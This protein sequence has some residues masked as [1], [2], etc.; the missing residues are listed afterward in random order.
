MQD[1]F[2]GYVTY[3]SAGGV[4]IRSYLVVP[5]GGSAPPGVL[6]LRG[7]AGPDDGYV[8]IANRFAKSG[9]GVLVHGWQVRGDDP[10]DQEVAADAS[11]ALKYLASRND[12][13]G[14]DIGVVGYCRGGAHGAHRPVLLRALA[15]QRCGGSGLAERAAQQVRILYPL[16]EFVAEDVGRKQRRRV[17]HRPQPPAYLH[18]SRGPLARGARAALGGGGLR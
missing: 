4:S 3:P 9:Y 10:P 15:G 16:D 11:A 12:L 18:G 17:G 8:E 6:I 5:P 2:A 14:R 13:R 1:S 7:V